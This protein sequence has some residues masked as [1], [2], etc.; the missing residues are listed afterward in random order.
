M[1]GMSTI[2]KAA[3]VSSLVPSRT[4]LATSEPLPS[5][6][7]VDNAIAEACQHPVTE[8]QYDIYP[9]A[10]EST[11]IVRANNKVKGKHLKPWYTSKRW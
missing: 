11:L 7:K 5:W 8:L 10:P 2:L 1:K 6:L 4:I 9:T 3:I